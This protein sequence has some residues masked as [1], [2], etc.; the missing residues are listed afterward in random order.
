MDI[1]IVAKLYVSHTDIVLDTNLFP[2]NKYKRSDL[3]REFVRYHLHAIVS[4]KG[5]D[6]LEEFYKNQKME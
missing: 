5:H 1:D 2:I 4:E 3:H 6:V